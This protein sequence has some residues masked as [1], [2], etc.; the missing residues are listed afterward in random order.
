MD[1]KELRNLPLNDNYSQ[2]IRKM[3]KDDIKHTEKRIEEFKQ[4]KHMFVKLKEGE[5]YWL[6][7]HSSEY[8]YEPCKVECVHCGLTNKFID[9]E[10]SLYDSEILIS[11]LYNKNTIETQYFYK[12]F[13]NAFIRG[14]KSFNECVFHLI[15]RE[16]L[17]T[18]HPQLLY[19]LALYIN[20]YGKKKELFEIMKKLHELETEEEKIRLQSEEQ[21]IALV[22]R[23]YTSKSKCLVLKK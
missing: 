5:K 14:G 17:P 10:R 20:P 8:Y 11:C 9:I 3:I 16:V 2:C 23:Y 4:C 15:S 12:F 21:A 7:Y 6:G 13:K 19:N 1:E 18:C 22:D